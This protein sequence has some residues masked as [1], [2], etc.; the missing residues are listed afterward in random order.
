VN[1]HGARLIPAT[2]YLEANGIRG[3]GEMEDSANWHRKHPKSF[4]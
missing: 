4:A 3:M 2:D 1:R